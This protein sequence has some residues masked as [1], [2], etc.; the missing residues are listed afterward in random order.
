MPRFSMRLP[1]PFSF[2]ASHSAPRRPY[3]TWW[4]VTMY[5]DGSETAW[6]TATTTMPLSVACLMTVLSASRS[7]GLITITFAPAEIKLRMS[8]ICSVGPPL[9]LATITFDTLPDAFACALIE[10]II[11]S[12]QP[13]PVSVFETQRRTSW[14]R[15]SAGCR[16]MRREPTLPRSNRPAL[17]RALLAIHDFPYASPPLFDMALLGRMVTAAGVV[18]SL[19]LLSSGEARSRATCVPAVSSLEELR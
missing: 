11:S 12:R 9:R 19:H 7:E 6:S 10:Q 13:L 14:G 8:A 1:L 5:A 17:A 2:W 4:L 15:C 18:P 16:H 3:A